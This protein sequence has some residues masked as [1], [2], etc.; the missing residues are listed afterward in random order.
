MWLTN[1]DVSRRHKEIALTK[2]FNSKHYCRYDTFDAIEVS[3]VNDIP[4]NYYG[5]MGV[6]IT[7]LNKH[8]PDQFEIV[9]EANHGND[10]EY[11]LFLP[12]VNGI[13][14]YKRLLIRRKETENVAL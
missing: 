4:Y 14:K 5:L 12:V 1:L 11:D 9:G 6:P 3:K 2:T 7:F 8:N 13:K 10:S